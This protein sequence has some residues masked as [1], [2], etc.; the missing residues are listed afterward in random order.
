MCRTDKHGFPSRYVPRTK[1]VKGFQ[2]G[3]IVKAIILSGKKVG[4]YS[5]PA[6]KPLF[7]ERIKL[8]LAQGLPP[9]LPEQVGHLLHHIYT[10]PVDKKG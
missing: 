1:F 9:L 4:T 2:T 5:L 8:H 10:L 3:D 6:K 7:L